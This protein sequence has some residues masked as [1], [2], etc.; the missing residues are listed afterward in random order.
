MNIKSILAAEEEEV[1]EEDMSDPATW[2]PG[3]IIKCVSDRDYYFTPNR[4]YVFKRLIYS[5]KNGTYAH[6]ERDDEGKPN[7]LRVD[8]FEWYS[9]PLSASL[10]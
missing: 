7:S 3:D 6:V 1:V 4:I 9:H 8:F 10:K 2:L 5:Y